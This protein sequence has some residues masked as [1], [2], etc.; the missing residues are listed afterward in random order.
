MRGVDDS[1]VDAKRE[2][3]ESDSVDP[4]ETVYG[5]VKFACGIV[6]VRG[7][8]E[9]FVLRGS[10]SRNTGARNILYLPVQGK[11]VCYPKT[12]R[13]PRSLQQS[14]HSHQQIHGCKTFHL[15]IHIQ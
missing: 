1:G 5:G 3:G 11:A 15:G 8:L 14:G 10:K 7:R 13:R 12:T 6:V 4:C 9:F 2:A